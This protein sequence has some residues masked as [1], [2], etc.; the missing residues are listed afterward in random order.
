MASPQV[1]GPRSDKQLSERGH[2]LANLL[3][4]L[5]GG[6]FADTVGVDLPFE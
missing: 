5:Y 6:G 1:V 3:F 4:H 2:N